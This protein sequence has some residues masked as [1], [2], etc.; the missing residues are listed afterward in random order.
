MGMSFPTRFF[1][2]LRFVQNDTEVIITKPLYNVTKEKS[3]R[4]YT[5]YNL[6]LNDKARTQNRMVT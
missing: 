1:T 2:P 4:L 5:K 3:D 6:S